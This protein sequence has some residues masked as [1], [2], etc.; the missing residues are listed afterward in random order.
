MSTVCEA[1]YI[2]DFAEHAGGGLRLRMRE[3]EIVCRAAGALWVEANGILIVADLHLEKGSSFATRGQMLP[4]YDTRETIARLETEVALLSPRVL[5]LLGDTFH[6][7]SGRDRLEASDQ[8]RL[9]TLARGRTLLWLAGNHDPIAPSDL[10][11]EAINA[12][13]VAGLD[14]V[15]EPT[16]TP[17]G[18]EVSGHLHPCARIRGR[19]FAVRRRCFITDGDRVILPAF[20]AYTGGLNVRDAAFDRLLRRRPLAAVMGIGRIHAIGWSSLEND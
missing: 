13:S 14:L 4:P 8:R 16:Q 11:G 10:P 9:E 17:G 2:Y 20:G 18:L 1:P 3:V 15:H 5:V 12:L 19:G 6:D 7:A